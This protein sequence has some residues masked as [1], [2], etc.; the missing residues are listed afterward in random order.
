MELSLY[1]I[2]LSSYGICGVNL[3]IL[4]SSSFFGHIFFPNKSRYCNV[5][6]LF[7]MLNFLI[8]TSL[9]INHLENRMILIHKQI[10][11]SNNRSI[12][13]SF[14]P[15]IN[16][17]TGNCKDF[18]TNEFSCPVMSCQLDVM[19]SHVYIMS[20]TRRKKVFR[21][22]ASQLFRFLILVRFVK[23][24]SPNLN[25][26]IILGCILSYISVI[27]FAFDGEHLKTELCTV[28]SLL[29]SQKRYF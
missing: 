14:Y 18:L 11:R 24:S 5:R 20:Y 17:A 26:M 13:V 10:T 7:S 21:V 23:M 29:F 16:F 4:P 27:L 15:N 22:P 19:Q 28:S 25:N 12:F 1:E 2:R 9:I 8:S 3:L 6:L